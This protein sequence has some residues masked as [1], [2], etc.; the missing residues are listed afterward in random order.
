MQKSPSLTKALLLNK[1]NVE[2]RMDK[3]RRKTE[4]YLLPIQQESRPNA[5]DIYP[6]TQLKDDLIYEGYDA[7]AKT[8]S[9]SSL[10]IIDGYQGVFFEDIA[11]GL[12]TE[13]KKLDKS[14]SL[15]QVQ[16]ALKQESEIELLVA[17]FLGGKDPLFGRKADL[18][19]SDFFNP[20]LLN[21]KSNLNADITIIYGVG[22]FLANHE[23]VKV[24]V[25]L[26]KS[27]VQYRARAQ[28][29]SNIGA[30][31]SEDF[32]SVYKRF[33]FIDWVVLNQHKADFINQIDIL[34]DD[35]RPA[36][37]VWMKGG[38]FRDSL[39]ALSRSV[40]RVRPWF[41]PGV[42]GGQWI[43]KNIKGLNKKAPN[44]AWSFELIVPENGLLF[45]SSGILLEV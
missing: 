44:Y 34:A 38:T 23:G 26:P 45:E 20:N 8:L 42:W 4:Q 18:K 14:V 11:Q 33:Y 15:I 13:F 12:K 28:S 25:D 43:K 5:Y 37:F 19:L 35:Q 6:S 10:I 7:L 24:Y 41:E 1:L 31:V 39:N 29:I 32:S 3:H 2:C 40:F 22:A 17:P 30:P 9:H 27:E 16:H 21:Q 36:H